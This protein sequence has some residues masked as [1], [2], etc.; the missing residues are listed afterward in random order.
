VRETAIHEFP[1]CPWSCTGSPAVVS[2]PFILRDPDLQASHMS[3]TDTT[4][5]DQRITKGGPPMG[6]GG[7]FC[8]S[9]F[10]ASQAFASW[11][12]ASRA[13]LPLGLL[14]LGSLPLGSFAFRAFLP[15]GSLFVGLLRL[16]GFCLSGFCASRAFASWAAACSRWASSRRASSPVPPIG[17]SGVVPGNRG[18]DDDET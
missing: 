16:L 6:G 3:V 9:G 14:P 12:F 1:R 5:R 7:R 11:V 18:L 8:L 2:W 15:L 17:P 4:P 10:C 13:F